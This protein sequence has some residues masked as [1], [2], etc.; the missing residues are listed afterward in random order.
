[1]RLG[2]VLEKLRNDVED[3]ADSDS[4][5]FDAKDLVV[6]TENVDEKNEKGTELSTEPGR[7]E[8]VVEAAIIEFDKAEEA[9][10]GSEAADGVKLDFKGAK[11]LLEDGNV[12]WEVGSLEVGA[13]EL[14][15][16]APISEVDA[17]TDTIDNDSLLIPEISSSRSPKPKIYSTETKEATMC[18]LQI[19]HGELSWV[20]PGREMQLRDLRVA[21]SLL[22]MPD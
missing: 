18:M 14:D 5:M 11:K 22:V 17:A 15:V 3:A 9:A 6:G 8:L 4:T 12:D 7:T 2:S 16:S 21:L 13:A 19:M 10:E 1:M 20:S